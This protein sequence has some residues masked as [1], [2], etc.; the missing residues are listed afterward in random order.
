M[1]DLN[2]FDLRETRLPYWALSCFWE[3]PN[4]PTEERA[5]HNAV[6][7]NSF[8]PLRGKKIDTAG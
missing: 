3:L 4:L 1:Q 2:N 5:G 7:T 8:H 6:F